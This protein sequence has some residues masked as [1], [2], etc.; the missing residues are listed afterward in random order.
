M[1][2]FPVLNDRDNLRLV[3]INE[4]GTI[5]EMIKTIDENFKNIAA[6]GGGPDG[7]PGM[8]GINGADGTSA[9]YIFA[10][11]DEE[12]VAGTHYPATDPDKGDLFDSVEFAG[13]TSFPSSTNKK[14]EWFDH[15]QGV[16]KEHKNEYVFSRY[17]RTSGENIWFYAEK[18]ELWAHWG[19][20]GKDGDGVEYIFMCSKTKLD[21]NTLKDSI[22]SKKSMSGDKYQPI[23]YQIDG[24]FPG[25]EWFKDDKNK[26]N[27]WKAINA[28]YGEVPSDFETLWS[29]RFNMIVPGYDWTDEPKGT[30]PINVYEYVAIRR[31]NVDDEDGK[32][33]GDFSM[34]AIWSHYGLSTRTIIIYCNTE[35]TTSPV[36]PQTGQGIWDESNGKLTLPNSLVEAGWKDT[37]ETPSETQITWMCSGI[38]DNSG[39]NVSWSKPMRITGK[40]GKQGEDGTTVEFIYALSKNMPA[41]PTI[42]KETTDS[43][44]G[45]INTKEELFDAAKN[46]N[47]E[48]NG[49]VWYDRAQPISPDKPTEYVWSRRRNK[50]SEPWEYDDEP[51]IWAHWGED[52]TDGDGVEYIFYITNTE[53]FDSANNPPKVSA[54]T[55]TTE[56][57][58]CKKLV[59]NMDDF[60]PN[61]NWFT[62]NELEIKKEITDAGYNVSNY[63]SVKAFFSKGW[64]DN[65]IKVSPMSPYQWVSIRRSHTDETTG[66]KRQWEDFSDPVLWNSYGKSTR[67]FIVY[68]NVSDGVLP[69]TLR[70]PVGGFWNVGTGKLVKD[71]KNLKTPYTYDALASG[72]TDVDR[73]N[74][75]NIWEDNNKDVD[76]KIAWMSSAI[77]GDDGKII[78][79]WSA[80]FRITGHNGENGA[81]GSNIEYIYA[82]CDDEASLK[83]PQN[84][85]DSNKNI[86]F[87]NVENAGTNGYKYENT[88]TWYDHPQGVSNENGK[89]TEWVWSRS[90]P[91]GDS[92]TAQWKY[93]PSAVKW[94]H[95]GE[96]GTD[97]DG[98][99]YIF[100]ATTNNPLL[101]NQKPPKVSE[102]TGDD[103]LGK[104]KKIIYNMREFFPNVDWFTQN[105]KNKVSAEVV[106]QNIMTAEEFDTLWTNHVGDNKD[107]FGFNLGWTDNPSGVDFE[108]PFEWVSIRRTKNDPE[109][110]SGKIWGDYSEPKIWGA[111]NKKT[112]LFMVYC[113]VDKNTTPDKP[114]ES[115]FS[116]DVQNDKL[117][118]AQDSTTIWSDTDID[119]PGTITWLCS[120][121]FSENG[122][123]TWSEPH[124]ITGAEGKAGA[125]GSNMEFIYAISESMVGGTNYPTT[126]KDDNPNSENTKEGLFNNVERNTGNPK[127][128]YYNNTFWYDRAQPIENVAG[129]R[130][131]YA[132]SRYRSAGTTEWTYDPKPF[133]WAH[134]GE[135]GT[136]GD[137]VE[138]IFM[139]SAGEFSIT[140]KDWNNIWSNA[141]SYWGPYGDA[142]YS[143]IDDLIPK[144]S[145]FTD[146]KDKYNNIKS[147]VKKI[148]EANGGTFNESDYYDAWTK[149]GNVLSF[150][151]VFIGRPV[152]GTWYDNP[153]ELT[154]SNRYQYVS[155][156]K[157]NNGEWG[158][159]SYP[160]LWGN[161]NIDTR[162]FMVY[163]NLPENI[164]PTAP[165]SNYGKWDKTKGLI[166]GTWNEKDEWTVA[167]PDKFAAPACTINN[168]IYEWSDKNEDVPGTIAWLCSGTYVEN[169]RSI[170]WSNPFRITGA[171]GK[172]GADG[173]N[174]QF[175]YALCDEMPKYPKKD[176]SMSDADYMVTLDSFF[177]DVNASDNEGYWPSTNPPQEDATKWTD[178][179]QGIKNI[180]GH[181]KEWVWS[182]SLPAGRNDIPDNWVYTDKP[183]IWSHWGEDGTDGDGVEYI[184]FLAQDRFST[185][186]NTWNNTWSFLDSTDTSD[187]TTRI[188]KVIYS[189][190]DFYPNTSWFN[191]NNK[192]NVSAEVV[193]QNIMTEEEFNTLWTNNVG[194]NKDYF[195]FNLGWTDN[196]QD[197]TPSNKYQYVSIRKT[198]NDPEDPKG[199]EWGAFS[200]PS[201]W[202][203]YNITKFNSVVFTKSKNGVNLGTVT[204]SGGTF[205]S[206]YPDPIKKD[207]VTYK[208]SDGPEATN[209]N[210]VVWMTSATFKEDHP[211]APYGTWSSPKKMTDTADFNVEWS[212]DDLTISQVTTLNTI[213]N[214]SDYNFGTLLKNNSYNENAAETAWRKAVKEKTMELFGKPIE[215]SDQSAEAVLMAT[216]SSSGGTWTNW[217]VSRVKGEQGEP[218][219]SIKVKG[220]IAYEVILD[221]GINYNYSTA[222]TA[223]NN[224]V[225]SIQQ[226]QEGR[227]LIVYP[228]SANSDGIYEGDVT[229][230]DAL[231]MWKY[232]NGE[233]VDYNCKSS[234]NGEDIGNTYESP[235]KHLILWDG[236]S[237]MDLGE[238]Q[239]PAGPAG[240]EWRILTR[241]ANDDSEGKKIF[242]KE[243]ADIPSAKYVGF[244]TYEHIAGLN[245]YEFYKEDAYTWSLFKGQDGNGYEY[246]FKTT[247]ENVAPSIP[248]APTGGSW[249]TTP[250]V[251][252]GDGISDKANPNYGWVDE[253]MEPKETS[254]YV[255]MCWRKYDHS[256]QKWTNFKGNGDTDKARLWQVYANSINEVKEYFYAAIVSSPS[257]KDLGDN[258]TPSS[259]D[260]KFWKSR[261]DVVWNK[262]NRYLFNREVI[263]YSDTTMSVLDPHLVA[264]Y[265]DGIL[266]VV[267]YY[268]LE[269]ANG[270]GNG[271]PGDTPPHMNKDG[272]TP[273]TSSKIENPAAGKDYWTNGSVPKISKEFPVLWNISLKTYE[274]NR[275]GV[276]TTPL[277]I[278]TY[279]QGA[280]GEDS[281]YADLDNEMD[282][283]QIDEKNTI[284]VNGTYNTT[285]RLYGGSTMMRIDDIDISG[286]EAIMKNG[287]TLTYYYDNGTKKTDGSANLT[288]KDEITFEYDN[289]THKFTPKNGKTDPIGNVE[290]NINCIKITFTVTKNTTLKDVYSKVVISVGHNEGNN[291]TA[292]RSVSY[293]FVGTTHPYVYSIVPKHSAI[294]FSS[295]TYTPNPLYVEVKRQAGTEK[296]SFDTYVSTQGFDLTYT[297]TQGSTTTSST[298]NNGSFKVSTDNL[299]PGD[300]ITFAV[301]VDNGGTTLDRETVY[302]LREGSDGPKGDA[303][304]GYRY[305]YAR[306]VASNSLLYGSYTIP[307]I[308][309]NTLSSDEPIFLLGNETLPASP[310]AKGAEESCPYEYRTERY[311]NGTSWSN[312]SEPITIAKYLT[313][314]NISTE[315]SNAVTNATKDINDNLNTAVSRL[316]TLTSYIDPS[317]GIFSGTIADSTKAAI[318]SGYATKDNVS[319][320]ISSINLGG[321]LVGESGT[322]T[323][324]TWYD[325]QNSK[326][327]DV[328]QR[329]SAAEGILDTAV[330]TTQLSDVTTAFDNFKADAHDKFAQMDRTVANAQFMTDEEGYLMVDIPDY[331]IW[332]NDEAG[333]SGPYKDTDIRN[334]VAWVLAS[335]L[336]GSDGSD[337]DSEIDET[338]IRTSNT[339]V[340]YIIPESKLYNTNTDTVV[341]VLKTVIPNFNIITQLDEIK[342]LID[343]E[344]IVTLN[345]LTGKYTIGYVDSGSKSESDI[346]ILAGICTYDEEIPKLGSNEVLVI[347]Y[348]TADI[349]KGGKDG[350][351]SNLTWKVGVAEGQIGVSAGQGGGIT[352]FSYVNTASLFNGPIFPH[353]GVTEQ[354]VERVQSMLTLNKTYGYGVANKKADNNENNENYNKYGELNTNGKLSINGLYEQIDYRLIPED[355]S[356][357]NII[358]FLKGSKLETAIPNDDEIGIG[359]TKTYYVATNDSGHIDYSYTVS[360]PGDNEVKF[361]K[362]YDEPMFKNKHI[363]NELE[364]EGFANTVVNNDVFRQTTAKGVS[365]D[366]YDIYITSK[367]DEIKLTYEYN[368][369]PGLPPKDN[370]N[371]TPSESVPLD[372]HARLKLVYWYGENP[373]PPVEDEL[374]SIVFFEYTENPDDPTVN[375][376]T[377][378]GNV[379]IF[380]NIIDPQEDVLLH[381]K[382][383]SDCGSDLTNVDIKYKLE[384]SNR[385]TYT[386]AFGTDIIISTITE[387]DSDPSE[388]DYSPKYL[389][390]L[391]RRDDNI[392]GVDTQS[393]CN[394]Q[395]DQNYPI[396]QISTISVTTFTSYL[397][398]IDIRLELDLP[399][400]PGLRNNKFCYMVI[401]GSYDAKTLQS[402]S[403]AFDEYYESTNKNDYFDIKEGGFL[404]NTK[405]NTFG[406]TN[407]QEI[408]T[409]SNSA[410][411]NLKFT[412]ATAELNKNLGMYTYSYTIIQYYPYD[413]NSF[414]FESSMTADVT[415]ERPWYT[416]SSNDH[417]RSPFQ[418]TNYGSNLKYLIDKIKV[419]VKDRERTGEIPPINRRANN[420]K[421]SNNPGVK[422]Y[423]DVLDTEKPYLIASVSEL[424]TISQM[425]SDGIACT[426]IMTKAGDS[427]SVFYAQA[428]D[429]GESQIYMRADEVGI[430][431]NYL[432]LNKK[433][434]TLTGNLYAKDKNKHI[435]AGVIG[436]SSSIDDGVKFFAGINLPSTYSDSEIKNA[437]KKAK[438]YVT[439]S[440][441]L[442]A[443]DA[444]ISGNITANNFSASDTYIIDKD[445]PTQYSFKKTSIM[446]A[447]RFE[448]TSEFSQ[449]GSTQIAK[450]YI[451][452]EPEIAVGSG[453]LSENGT[454]K[455]LTNVPTLCM[456]YGGK[457]Y[458]LTPDMWKSFVPKTY[459]D[460]KMVVSDSYYEIYVTDFTGEFYA[461]WELWVEEIGNT[462]NKW[463]IE[464][465]G[466]TTQYNKP[467]Q[468]I[469][470]PFASTV[471]ANN[472]IPSSLLGK[473]VK[474]CL[475]LVTPFSDSNFSG[476]IPIATREGISIP[477]KN[478]KAETTIPVD[479]WKF[480]FNETAPGTRTG[481]WSITY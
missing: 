5:S 465:N 145:W 14:I 175:I 330:T 365:K 458:Y 247:S 382:V 10:L 440:G 403:Q 234:P 143:I 430:K 367:Y 238:L 195:G 312:W 381:M 172:S 232:V 235:N 233:W 384:T 479:G 208:W 464:L 454:V 280:N 418:G 413:F 478:D 241:Y 352:S 119:K 304:N 155:I 165:N 152:I 202:S 156:R 126:D 112:R 53:T 220:K 327:T 297:I 176:S 451:S 319:D 76:D 298:L 194:N 398:N 356:V 57:D 207:G 114:A 462:D 77:F 275:A 36:S 331:S 61:E 48:Y 212:S 28:K 452:V 160:K 88:T 121:L 306:Y 219:T 366:Y 92:K 113:N 372:N 437:V 266:D 18:P 215:F 179:P 93:A 282:S 148:I 150:D 434:L 289:S 67:T 467:S 396:S 17:K 259:I 33:W 180:D 274:D 71:E 59:Y 395:F 463:T 196:P 267:D 461:Q 216:C 426:S 387:V 416:D 393:Q 134:W 139:L 2:E 56:L 137:G 198:K 21:E 65:P 346:S 301:N 40:D 258:S 308:A 13:S 25:E 79:E 78:G 286:E 34:P 251:I 218:G 339:L 11:C 401:P 323:F 106:K 310:N 105:N 379:S 342:T 85:T 107:Y 447:D 55:G 169:G 157:M 468:F 38:F 421:G 415:S 261:E 420:K 16:S 320:A 369:T 185:L 129:K 248:K 383:C 404:N 385:I 380:E 223:K 189:R 329:M 305:Y 37:N 209:K 257:W 408:N 284:L 206:P 432:T 355:E 476:G 50:E 97:G 142:I 321:L 390:I 436:D 242:V 69:P 101:D 81:D 192:G 120:G 47:T 116:W 290:L 237:W 288:L 73:E 414:S 66:G 443:E 146:N 193:K 213:L 315:V 229:A 472:T 158:K 94:S 203:K 246:I 311:Y 161:Y 62:K 348:V 336:E 349:S 406:I 184:F 12:L 138:Y 197:L 30:D 244:L 201:L 361:I 438:F 204:V 364:S 340:P 174:I 307:T 373:E 96:D 70:T 45:V 43:K 324:S 133:V 300:Y 402:L 132:W 444:D 293:T 186:E 46:A 147:K 474:V 104:C 337:S 68:C 236:D 318:L 63:D 80:P 83:Y 123:V 314:G 60:Y 188:K 250:N 64:S 299:K 200:Y 199:K 481:V 419:T 239:G 428:V 3:S 291:E 1:A 144:R 102:I 389:T 98:V 317:T 217:V 95:W 353:Y 313:V 135:D 111:Y 388:S 4:N 453:D 108:H 296:E 75:I 118:K 181:R 149:V 35:D 211:D 255:W 407:W 260:T 302:V 167:E 224:K 231:Y 333:L 394:Y 283:I 23:I 375:I 410:S 371:D 412:N 459:Y 441:H 214:N 377:S 322:E 256:T 359:K 386:D 350:I 52:G 44:P 7:L 397:Q 399:N 411:I 417:N 131:E 173:S 226:P 22:K 86:F 170:S 99:E 469:N 228:H 448:V 455:K 445:K 357:E 240:K 153:Q 74:H 466:T 115:D 9:E 273:E 338:T 177:D 117:V 435:T 15:P 303:G 19:E 151:E 222:E 51:I 89:R 409:D 276:W 362:S 252:P 358:K 271:D 378:K 227:L 125:D 31:C 470:G 374:N 140:S 278:G 270:S 295:D 473:T 84:D 230:G 477:Y 475:V 87:N 272:I 332:F 136:D 429:G 72:V 427:T 343:R 368:I 334:D 90:K 285:V 446:N 8:D 423:I 178:N 392:A 269:S 449:D 287:Y 221:D 376:N 422:N 191:D 316:N 442:H 439:E 54:I 32:E 91:A 345:K 262:T 122:D 328:T 354:N 309:S 109:D 431:S 471:G 456:Q 168:T 341:F 26:T 182:R 277:V 433:G 183:V 245:P 243:D 164:T 24:F 405:F 27:V 225:S 279:G 163:C 326:L 42:E 335:I 29:N 210:E 351:F 460:V 268:I 249:S 162:V 292:R 166:G 154:P 253:P 263:Y 100:Y 360:L 41:H 265:E 457:N 363:F 128:H 254:K 127:G 58:K 103:N 205:D 141:K 159:F 39:K 425:V 325:S 370:G 187:I 130:T 190:D 124:R 49:Q 294:V 264:T 82:L 110:T 171:D 344:I 450:I 347:M 20:T 424:A 391:E 281:I 400:S 6:H 480:T